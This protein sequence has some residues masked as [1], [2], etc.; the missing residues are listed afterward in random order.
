MAHMTQNS[1]TIDE[2]W[3]SVYGCRH[4]NENGIRINIQ[5]RDSAAVGLT[6]ELLLHSQVPRDFL[7]IENQPLGNSR[8]LV[9]N[10][11]IL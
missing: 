7:F 4:L 3:R 1:R 9:E 10:G 6:G 5:A 8:R 11:K 2:K